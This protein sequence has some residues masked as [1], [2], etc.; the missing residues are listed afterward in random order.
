MVVKTPERI[1]YRP[2]KDDGA[3]GRA[4]RRR[5]EIGEFHALIG[6]PVDIRRL[7]IGVAMAAHFVVTRVVRED[8]HD[9]GTLGGIGSPVRQYEKKGNGQ[10]A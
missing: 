6:E 1:A 2:V 10:C 3:T 9:V 8:E 7:D 5:M 4:E